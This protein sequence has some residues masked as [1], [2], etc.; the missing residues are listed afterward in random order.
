MNFRQSLIRAA[1]EAFA[2]GEISRMQMI[3]V[4]MQSWRPAKLREI[5]DACCQELQS[6]GQM[7]AAGPGAIDWSALL[8]FLKELLPIILTFF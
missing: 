8:A 3:A 2:N 6:R 4:R 7:P 1:E 5:Q